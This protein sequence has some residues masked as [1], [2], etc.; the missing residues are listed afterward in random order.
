MG[1]MLG[2]SMPAKNEALLLLSVSTRTLVFATNVLVTMAIA[3]VTGMERFSNL[4]VV[5]A[6]LVSLGGILQGIS[7]YQA[8]AE[9]PAGSAV[10]DHPMG[11]LLAVCA[12]VLDASRWVLLQKVFKER[13]AQDKAASLGYMSPTFGS[14]P[15]YTHTQALL[16]AERQF[17]ALS[18]RTQAKAGGGG[19]PKLRMV[20]AVMWSSA[21]V[22]LLGSLVVE[23]GAAEQAMTRAYSLFILI[24]ELSISALGINVC[25][26]G[27]VQRTSA[28]TFTIL[29]NLHS[30]PMLMSGIVCFADEVRALEIG[31]FVVCIMGSLLYSLAKNQEARAS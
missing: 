17:S 15:S 10:V 8:S 20:S 29:S 9:M 14:P 28:V 16:S 27:V 5:A 3:T 26:F 23:P 12:L 21:P 7:H 31:G 22:M 2:L 4:K 6:A 25:E 18:R 30:I 11:Y 1:V 19:V 13:R 24:L